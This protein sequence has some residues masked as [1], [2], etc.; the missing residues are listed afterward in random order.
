[1]F[2]VLSECS[3]IIDSTHFE[4]LFH[5]FENNIKQFLK[6]S[7]YDGKYLQYVDITDLIQYV[8]DICI[9]IQLKFKTRHIL[10][11]STSY[12]FWNFNYLETEM[13]S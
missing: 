13:Y 4:Y 6:W 2:E 8:N 5:L 12:D 7:I 1:M 11:I 10:T 3:T 9:M